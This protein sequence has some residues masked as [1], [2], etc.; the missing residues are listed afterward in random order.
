M[1]HTAFRSDSTSSPVH[2]VAPAFRCKLAR[3]GRGA[4]WTLVAGELDDVTAPRLARML[5]E[6]TLRA[7]RGRSPSRAT[8]VDV[9]ASARVAAL[10]P[11]TSDRSLVRGS[12]RTT[13][14]GFQ[15]R[16]VLDGE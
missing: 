11:T 16:L 7:A 1:Q 9:L 14:A 8:R 13:A 12:P 15:S 4:T 6:G 2:A 10:A 3:G 5:R